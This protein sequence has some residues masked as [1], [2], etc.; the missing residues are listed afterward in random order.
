MTTWMLA[1]FAAAHLLAAAPAPQEIETIEYRIKKGDT[2]SGLARTFY[3]D[4]QR[5][6]VIHQYNRWLGAQLPH[7]LEEGQVLVLPKSLP[8]AL[9][10][11]EVTAAQRKVEARAPDT[12]DWSSARPGLDLYRGWR[13]NTHERASAE[14]TFRD[15]SRIEMR[16]NTLVIIYGG[17]EAKARRETS[18]AT[19][20]RGALRSRLG[21]YTGKSE[22]ALTVTTPSAVAEFEGGASLVTVDD[23]GTSRVANHGEGKAAVRSSGGKS[24]AKVKVKPKMGSKVAK[25]KAPSKPKPLP[26]TPAWIERGATKFVA[27]ADHG[28][29]IQGE[30]GAIAGAAS[31]RVEVALRPDGRELL[32]A[33]TVP[34][35]VQ[36]FEVRGLPPGDYYVSV[37]AVDDDAFESAPSER[38]RLSLVSVGLRAPGNAPLPEAAGE[39][40]DVQAPPRV[41]RGTRLDVPRELRCRV[42]GGEPSRAPVLDEVGTSLIDCL[43]PSDQPVPGFAVT[44]VDV[45]VAAVAQAQVA[46]RGQTTFAAFS[47]DADAPL[48]QRLWVEAPEGVLVGVPTPKDPTPAEGTRQWQVRVHADQGAP[49][50]ATLRIMADASGEPVALGELTLTVDD[51]PPTAPI[52]TSAEPARPER[53]MIEGGVYGGVLMPSSRHNLFQI[54]FAE[55]IE[56]QPLARVA[57][58]LGLRLGYYPIRWV[59]VELEEGLAPTRTRTTDDRVTLFTVR[60][61]ALAQM[62]WRITPTVHVGGGVVGSAASSV[63]GGEVDAAPYFGAGLK[64]YATRWAVARLDVRD[65]ITEARGDGAAHSPEVTLGLSVVLGRRS[66]A[67]PPPREHKGKTKRERR[68]KTKTKPKPKTVENAPPATSAPS[69]SPAEPTR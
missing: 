31:Y 40:A 45:K 67:A 3:G 42:D 38:L 32:A 30:W 54:K 20:D 58:S 2:C 69:S 27:A 18:E 39:D 50:A 44:V 16:E 65:V 5:H 57:P 9:P 23:G 53:H 22:R 46:T 15:D 25:G 4:P 11:A 63:L 7:H 37:A 21:A 43:T 10:D 17:S 56:W 12:A 59:G 62:P 24:R 51:P 47:I 60:A 6:D 49:R 61:H 36:R 66:A 26:P 55:D 64:F 48:P 34:A 29:T 19:L 1:S 28:G 52:V 41:L 35:S 8:P 68:T 14:I 13:V 33:Q